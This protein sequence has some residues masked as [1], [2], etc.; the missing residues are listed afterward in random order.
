[1]TEQDGTSVR[2]LVDPETLEAIEKI[3]DER[4]PSTNNNNN[5]VYCFFCFPGA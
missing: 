1:M 3:E 2:S 4:P 5:S